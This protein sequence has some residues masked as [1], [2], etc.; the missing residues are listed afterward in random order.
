MCMYCKGYEEEHGEKAERR[1]GER[2]YP[3][4]NA[5]AQPIDGV[6]TRIRSSLDGLF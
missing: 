2:N 4:Q 3:A 1:S 6:L 5:T